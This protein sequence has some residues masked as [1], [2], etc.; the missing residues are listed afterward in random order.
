MMVPSNTRR[1]PARVHC[2]PGWFLVLTRPVP[3]V[4]PAALLLLLL[5]A[6][7]ML[8]VGLPWLSVSDAVAAAA[9][10]ECAPEI[11]AAAVAAAEAAGRELGPDRGAR[12]F[13]GREGVSFAGRSVAV[14]GICR[15]VSG[16]SAA[17]R[18]LIS[19]LGARETE[20]T[21]E[22][23]L[24]GDVLFAFDRAELREEARSTL[25][26]IA[27]VIAEQKRPRV[28]IT[29]HTDA[30]GS[31]AYNLDLSERRA[32][33]VRDDLVGRGLAAE[34]FIVRGCGETD[35]RAPNTNPD[36]SDNAAGRKANRRVELVIFK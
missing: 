17:M 7:P 12:I 26:D 5:S 8:P 10:A 9:P 23:E 34:L 35:P 21:I 19:D 4:V 33:A 27:A 31:A 6:G 3:A 15:Q 32:A 22:L 16:R 1:Q 13:A 36:G 20:T 30:K 25:D 29:G 24:S 14:E 11:P 2:R 28:E 18:T